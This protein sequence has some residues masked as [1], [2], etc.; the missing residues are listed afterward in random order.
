MMLLGWWEVNKANVGFGIRQQIQAAFVLERDR[1]SK[2][3]MQRRKER[4][5]L[6]SHYLQPGRSWTLLHG[7]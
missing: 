4:Q 3:C 2:L 7:L 5:E 6:P 1:S